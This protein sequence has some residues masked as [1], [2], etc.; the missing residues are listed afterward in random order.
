MS[1]VDLP[2]VPMDDKLGSSREQWEMLLKYNI[3]LG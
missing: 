1:I 3:E 2:R